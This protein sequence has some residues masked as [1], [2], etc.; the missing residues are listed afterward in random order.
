MVATVRR[1]PVSPR[2]ESLSSP[3]SCRLRP[4]PRVPRLPSPEPPSIMLAL[5]LCSPPSSSTALRRCRGRLQRPRHRRKAGTE[6]VIAEPSDE[7]CSDETPIPDAVL[8][9]VA[10]LLVAAVGALNL[11]LGDIAEDE[12]NWPPANPINANREEE[13]D[14]G[15]QRPNTT[16]ST[17]AASRR[18]S[19]SGSQL[20]STASPLLRGVEPRA[21]CRC[22]CHQRDAARPARRRILSASARAR[23]VASATLM[24]TTPEKSNGRS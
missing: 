1:T 18:A 5:S 14:Q 19:R 12:A 10:L 22:G 20:A 23:S 4:Q 16:I 13:A 9:G 21:Q 24:A 7:R 8:V 2:R 11:S 3:R 17:Q 15:R 6:D